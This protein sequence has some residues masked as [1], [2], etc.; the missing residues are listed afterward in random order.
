MVKMHL[1]NPLKMK[2]LFLRNKKNYLANKYFQCWMSIEG[3]SLEVV[4]LSA[5]C[6]ATHNSHVFN[7]YESTP[8]TL[9]TKML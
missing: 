5:T 2:D 8:L 4:N 6:S 9:A 3:I 1:N 7:S